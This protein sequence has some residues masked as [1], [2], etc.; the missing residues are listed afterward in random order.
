MSNPNS[1]AIGFKA[2]EINQD[3]FSVAIGNQ[4]G[5]KN[6]SYNSIAIGVNAGQINQKTTSIA[7][8]DSAGKTD[9]ASNSL[10][11]GHNAGQL[12]QGNYS[13][14]IG[15][16][17][18]VTGQSPNSIIMNA[19]EYY[20]DASD[21]AFYVSPIRSFESSETI[22]SLQYDENTCEIFNNTSKNFIIDHPS[23]KE[24]YLVHA[25]LEGPEAGVYY[26]GKGEIVDDDSVSIELPEYVDKFA[27][28]FTV[29]ITSISS[30][31]ASKQRIYDVSE[32]ENGSFTVY[33]K[34]GKFN[35]IVYG[36]R[37]Q[38]NAEPTKS[39][40]QVKG[41]GPYKW[42]YTIEDLKWHA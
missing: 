24:R 22:G 36:E 29:H 12:N 30:K 28:N 26:R 31:D 38:I 19:S 18:G 6:Q 40:V 14:A 25:C 15:L 13:I 34:N 17:A 21:S 11:I 10:A 42:I 16:N 27:T 37:L 2:G 35:W 7:I 33:G 9:Q 3:D 23:D 20:V 32:V 5:Q 1:V 41:D 39:S 4:A 8:G